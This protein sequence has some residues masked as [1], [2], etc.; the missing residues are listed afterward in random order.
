MK[1]N[2][3]IN[4][5]YGLSELPKKTAYAM[6][7]IPFQPDN[8]KQYTPD[9]GLVAGTMYPALDKPFYGSKCGEKS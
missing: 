9:Q 2:D 8:H 1:L 7:Y 5:Q 3:L 4:E 6:A